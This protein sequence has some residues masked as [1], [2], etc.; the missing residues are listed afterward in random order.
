MVMVVPRPGLVEGWAARRLD[1]SREAGLDE[2]PQGVIDGLGGYRAQALADQGRHFLD[3]AMA[4]FLAQDVEDGDP[5]CGA[6]EAGG[7]DIALAR[8]H[9]LRY[10]DYL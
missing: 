2:R 10:L 7:P 6:P 8:R 9:R 3:R 1:S 4:P 5:L